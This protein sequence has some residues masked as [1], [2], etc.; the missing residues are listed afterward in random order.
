MKIR[1]TEKAP[2]N[3]THFALR[4]VL[5]ALMAWAAA[6]P[7]LGQQRPDRNA[8]TL[9]HF[10]QNYKPDDY[11]QFYQNWSIVEDRRGV[12]YVANNNGVMEF[13]GVNWRL[14]KLTDDDLTFSVAADS[15]GRIFAGGIQ[16][17]GY[18]APDDSMRLVFRSLKPLLPDSLRDFSEVW[19]IVA[20]DGYVYFQALDQI[21]R[22]D[23][24]ARKFKVWKGD[25]QTG[26][27]YNGR[28]FIRERGVGLKTIEDGEL[29]LAPDGA[30]FADEP[31]YKI[32]PIAPSRGVAVTFSAGLLEYDGSRFKPFANE[33]DAYLRHSEPFTACLLDS[34]LIAVGTLRGGVAVVD[35]DGKW[36]QVFNKEQGL[37]ANDVNCVYRSRQGGF[38][39][40]LGIGL[41]WVEYPSPLTWLQ[42]EE[43]GDV[44][45][46]AMRRSGDRLLMGSMQGLYS[47]T[48]KG[49]SQSR[50]APVPIASHNVYALA[51]IGDQ[52]F[53]G[54]ETA[55]TVSGPS[56]LQAFD[57]SGAYALLPVG[58]DRLAVGS[59]PGVFIFRKVNGIWRQEGKVS[60]KGSDY[61]S[62]IE[63]PP[64]QIWAGTRDGF[65]MR[66]SL[67]GAVD[68][69]KP[70]VYGASK[71]LHSA[72]TQLQDCFFFKI[73]DELMVHSSVGIFRYDAASDRF[74]P[75]ARFGERFTTGKW[76]VSKVEPDR[77]RKGRYWL[78]AFS[79]S[80]SEYRVYSATRGQQGAYEVK[81]ARFGRIGRFQTRSIFSEPDG[82]VWLGTDKGLLRY[83]QKLETGYDFAY[84]ALLRTAKAGNGVIF[85]GTIINADSAAALR[86]FESKP[87]RVKYTDNTVRFDFAALSFVQ[88]ALNEF[89]HRLEGFEEEWSD[90]SR[91]TYKE[92]TNL[93]EGEYVFQVRARNAY[94]IISETAEYTFIVQPP[95]YRTLWAYGLFTL[96]FFSLTYGVFRWR[97]RALAEA[98]RQ[99]EHKVE[100]R[101]AEVVR[102]SQQLEQQNSEI[103]RQ[104]DEIEHQNMEITDSIKYASRIQEAILPSRAAIAAAF[105]SSFV[106]YKPKD[107]VSG[108]FYWFAEE[109]GWRLIAAVDCTG[110]GIPGAFMSV[111]G[112]SL[113]N[114]I[115]SEKR[116]TDPGTI[117][118]RL[119]DLVRENLH[120]L[121]AK[122]ES[123]DGMDLMLLAFPPDDTSKAL[124]SGAN[125]PLYLIRDGELTELKGHKYPI[126]GGQYE[127]RHFET[128]ELPLQAG[129]LLYI[130]SDGYADQFGGPMRRKFMYGK[131]KKMLLEIHQRPL[132]EQREILDQTIEAWRAE[133]G[134]DQIDDILVIGLRPFA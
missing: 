7:L 55:L 112:S 44:I 82:V 2:V 106:L 123:K 9:N 77:W 45:I 10:I 69:I 28:Y 20:L 129:D 116:I 26:F 18:L 125:N 133:S 126:G 54:S 46:Q 131:F 62:L 49:Q 68:S 47:L 61:L 21:M 29:K 84:S 95:W 33:A 74:M 64:G 24:Q 113:L 36:R 59:Q 31:I 11:G 85:Y 121:D 42:Q 38:W 34:G 63:H 17:I 101:T 117:L 97:T 118:N 100:E 86:E 94:G 83:D 6:V 3:R 73:D 128:T 87:L 72:V 111:L 56:G 51:S 80:T 105:P 71:G 75:D 76:G 107:I 16:Q 1:A 50:V 13:D 109:N 5:F 114:Q 120:Q 15:A 4:A 27:A 35:K 122:S 78:A 98:N 92:Y 119:N 8:E 127:D 57:M 53:V 12:L 14:I 41:S 93:P 32:V 108:D 81:Q 19:S 79:T 132:L 91:E 96:A 37:L 70:V 90:W 39:V 65:A 124:Y 130:F 48:P 102:Q 40:G 30:R 103:M 89:Q 134:V 110:H 58:A 43:T 23:H 104:K 67:G 66:F 60:A 88:H 52:L 22:W 25:F 99:L 115:V